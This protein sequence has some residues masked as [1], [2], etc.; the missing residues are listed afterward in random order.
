M[1]VAIALHVWGVQSPQPEES[2]YAGLASRLV[3]SVLGNPPL[4]LAP[5]LQLAA[6]ARST[7]A[8]RVTIETSVL[9]VPPVPGPP[10]PA[11]LAT[12]AP[13][14]PIGTSGA[15]IGQAV[16]T[17]DVAPR[18]GPAGPPA[19]ATLDD[20]PAPGEPVESRPAAMITA[21]TPLPAEPSNDRL[22]PAATRIALPVDR[23]EAGPH[24]PS[25]GQEEVILA[26]LHEYTRALERFDFRATKAVY[27]SVNDRELR[28]S[29]AD[30]ETMRFKFGQC[31]VSFSASGQDANAWC[32]GNS[33][34][35]PKIGSRVIKYSDQAW[36]FTL[37]RDEGG[38]QIREARIQ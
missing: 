9:N 15:A 21:S 22:P 36:Q 18:P 31:G 23:K 13:L 10:V 6:T 19:L 25:D 20:G 30:L 28:Q 1:G 29:F 34:F 26:V 37:A 24:D 7:A 4:P 16:N 32:I 27:P 3:G 8:Q 2:L 14:V 33:T 12:A 38:W 17:P 11:S 5:P 35:R